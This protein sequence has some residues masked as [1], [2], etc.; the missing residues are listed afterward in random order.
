MVTVK[1]RVEAEGKSFEVWR[2]ID[3]DGHQYAVANHDRGVEERLPTDKEPILLAL[4]RVL[5]KGEQ[6][7]TEVEAVSPCWAIRRI[8]REGDAKPRRKRRRVS[9]MDGMFER[10]SKLKRVEKLTQEPDGRRGE[11]LH[12][13]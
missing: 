13:Q 4:T 3:A 8:I 12:E 1:L 10:E 9:K 2:H 5:L 7:S 6:L 11:A